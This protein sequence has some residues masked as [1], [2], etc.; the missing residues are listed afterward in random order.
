MNRLFPFVPGYF[1]YISIALQVIC[2]LHCLRKGT[3]QRWIWIIVFLPFIGSIAYFFT[4][5]LSGRELGNLQSGIGSL[6]NPAGRISRLENNLRFTDT[7]NNRVMLADAYL[8]VGRTEEAIELYT[9]SLTGAF[10][11][12]EY[13]ISQLI[14]AY[15]KQGRYEEL[16][17][18]AEKIYQ[19]PEFARSRAQLQYA[20]A[21]G[22]TGNRQGAEKEFK[23]MKARFSA[24]EA[25]YQYGKFLQHDGREDEARLIFKDMAEEAPHLSARERRYNRVWILKAKEELKR[26]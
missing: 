7:F 19:R 5:I 15:F 26:A 20:C 24:F 11:E 4:E 8:A 12:N 17:P 14:A 23:K 10:T 3:Q 22:Y 18:L 6:L 16:I 25:R 2:V 1:Y 13:V 9:S 21:L